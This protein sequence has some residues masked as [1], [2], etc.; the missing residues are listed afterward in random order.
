MRP[1]TNSNNSLEP[2]IFLFETGEICKQLIR[3]AVYTNNIKLV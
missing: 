1:S 3:Q 2:R